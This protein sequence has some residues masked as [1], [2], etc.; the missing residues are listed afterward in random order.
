MAWLQANFSVTTNPGHPNGSHHL[1]YLYGL[2]RM[3]MLA[4][5]RFI[6]SHDWY[7]QGADLLLE[8]QTA[9]GAWGNHVPTSFAILFLKR[10]TR[11]PAVQT[12]GG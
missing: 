2:E 8:K 12:T 3:G 6:G 11:G 1:Y 7:K 4:D 5:R 10:A 9:A